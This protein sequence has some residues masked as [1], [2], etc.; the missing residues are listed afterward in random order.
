MDLKK[1]ETYLL[2][3]SEEEYL[4]LIK[5]RIARL[6]DE[7]QII[8]NAREVQRLRRLTLLDGLDN[9]SDAEIDSIF[10][11]I[12]DSDGD[13]CEHGRSYAKHCSACGKIDYTMFPELFGKD[14]FSIE[15]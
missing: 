8:A 6:T 2:S 3:L 14:G 4:V 15:E 9:K 5:E 12:I 10:E 1:F 13:A 7:Q 11:S